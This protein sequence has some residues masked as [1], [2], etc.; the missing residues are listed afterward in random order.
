LDLFAGRLTIVNRVIDIYQ[1]NYSKNLQQLF[2]QDAGAMVFTGCCTLR[3]GMPDGR[4]VVAIPR[5]FVP[6]V[7]MEKVLKLSA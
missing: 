5:T 1:L 2:T 7:K 3:A 4:R 6:V